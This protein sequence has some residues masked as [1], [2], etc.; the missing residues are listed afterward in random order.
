MKLTVP[1]LAI[2]ALA[3]F[4]SG[5]TFIDLNALPGGVISP[6]GSS[7]IFEYATASTVSEDGTIIA[8]ASNAIPVRYSL[9][10]NRPV[11]LSG[12]QGAVLGVANDGSLVGWRLQ[13]GFQGIIWSPSNAETVVPSLA[14]GSTYLTGVSRDGAVASG[15]GLSGSAF[16]AGTYTVAGGWTPLGSRP[17][18]GSFQISQG[19][20]R[21]GSTVVGLDGA[22][23]FKWTQSGGFA[24]LETLVGIASPSA[25]SV[26]D[27]SEDGSVV[28]G[29]TFLSDG[30]AHGT[31]W[32]G[33]T[34]TNIGRL[35]GFNDLFL[36]AVNNDGTAAVGRANTFID[37]IPAHDARNNR[38]VYWSIETGLIDLNDLV[39][40]LGLTVPDG[41]ILT[42]GAD[43]SGDGSVIVGNYQNSIGEIRAFH[44]TIPSPAGAT[45]LAMAGLLAARRRRSN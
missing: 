23:G 10:G 40:S 32:D 13:S 22:G 15:Y 21:D 29:S 20:S 3:G 38:A 18:T 12:A 16:I 4:A 33:N 37:G 14:G 17:G 7:G 5:Q 42:F 28:V 26:S 24:P 8:G 35:A 39:A 45:T 1:A 41:G 31:I 34:P 25:F 44:L 6:G 30:F 43:I 19:I 27:T 36:T 11:A 9:D 2:A